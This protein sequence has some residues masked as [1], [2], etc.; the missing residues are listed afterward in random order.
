[1]GRMKLA[2]EVRTEEQDDESTFSRME[3]REATLI[4]ME[5]SMIEHPDEEDTSADYNYSFLDD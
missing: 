1:M 5:E 2:H 4:L 3:Q